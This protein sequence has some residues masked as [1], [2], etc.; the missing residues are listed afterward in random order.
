MHTHADADAGAAVK[1]TWRRL[2]EGPTH[3]RQRTH[4]LSARDNIHSGEKQNV[5]TPRQDGGLTIRSR[6]CSCRRR[7]WRNCARARRHARAQADADADDDVKHAWRRLREGPTQRWQR[8]HTLSAR[9]TTITPAQNKTIA[10]FAEMGG[11]PSLRRVGGPTGD[12]RVTAP[13]HAG[14]HAHRQTQTPA[15]TSNTRDSDIA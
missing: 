11:S 10:R 15:P 7:P 14:M 4:A 6:C 9:A 3:R 1:P 2:L 13:A 12:R 5:N 8:T